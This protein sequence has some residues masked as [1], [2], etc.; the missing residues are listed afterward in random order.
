MEIQMHGLRGN[1]YWKYRGPEVKICVEIQGSEVKICVE[2]QGSEV[3]NSEFR[4]F[5]LSCKICME[6]W[7]SYFDPLSYFDHLS[8]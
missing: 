8:Y 6:K 2:I 4:K 3:V 1:K 7:V 5:N